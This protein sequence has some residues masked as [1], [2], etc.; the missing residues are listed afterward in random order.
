[1]G[2]EDAALFAARMQ[3]VRLMWRLRVGQYYRFE[4]VRLFAL[5]VGLSVPALG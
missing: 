2:L 4:F 3:A 1:M 5:S